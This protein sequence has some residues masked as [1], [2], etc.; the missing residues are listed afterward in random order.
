MTALQSRTFFPRKICTVFFYEFS[1]VLFKMIF[2]DT[3]PKG[4]PFTNIRFSCGRAFGAD[5][6]NFPNDSPQAQIPFQNPV[7]L[8]SATQSCHIHPITK[9][10]IIDLDVFPWSL[11]PETSPVES[12]VLEN[13]SFFFTVMP[14][15]SHR[16]TPNRRFGRV[17]VVPGP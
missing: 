2:L 6:G 9:H 16:K 5:C 1:T 15:S 12:I 13:F 10:Q 4:V 14:Y 8:I 11:D 7:L 17:P 3:K